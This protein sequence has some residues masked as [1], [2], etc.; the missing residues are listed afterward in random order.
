MSLTWGLMYFSK[1]RYGTFAF[2]GDPV[3]T[4]KERGS[5]EV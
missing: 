3:R 4:T 2:S 1:M 5:L